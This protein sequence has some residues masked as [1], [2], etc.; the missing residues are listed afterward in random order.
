M[1]LKVVMVNRKNLVNNCTKIEGAS[2]TITHEFMLGTHKLL[3]IIKLFGGVQFYNFDLM[4]DLFGQQVVGRVSIFL[5][6]LQ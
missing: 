4:A 1:K 5:R 2:K 6:T 3:C